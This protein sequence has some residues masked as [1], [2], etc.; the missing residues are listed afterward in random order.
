MKIYS[1][2]IKNGKFDDVIGHLGNEIKNNK[3]T[4]SFHLAWSEV[5]AHTQS[6][7]LIFMDHDAIPVCGFSWIHWLVA[8][9]DPALRELKE[10]ISLEGKLLEGVNSWASKFLPSNWQLSKEEA[11]SFGGCAPPD[12]PHDYTIELYAL[13]KKLDLERG[14]FMNELMKKMSGHILDKA[15]LEVLYNNK[16]S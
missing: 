4:H 8:N 9:I 1:N 12:Q 6:L 15:T 14:F 2:N 13:D 3:P 10:N 16:K 11:T 5:P 7:A